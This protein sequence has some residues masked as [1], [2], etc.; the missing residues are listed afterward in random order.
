MRIRFTIR[1]LAWLTLLIAIGLAA[2]VTLNSRKR[3]FAASVEGMDDSCMTKLIA[4]AGLPE[5]RYVTSAIPPAMPKLETLPVGIVDTIMM[6]R[7]CRVSFVSCRRSGM[8]FYHFNNTSD[9]D[10]S[11]FGIKYVSSTEQKGSTVGM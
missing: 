9:Y 2:T 4:D 7:R 11:L 1:T 8:M 10:V 6:R 5:T 3:N